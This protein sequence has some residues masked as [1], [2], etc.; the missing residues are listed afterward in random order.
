[1]PRANFT[2]FFSYFLTKIGKIANIINICYLDLFN[3]EIEKDFIKT[4]GFLLVVFL[5]S[6]SKSEKIMV[7]ANNNL[8]IFSTIAVIYY[9]IIIYY[10]FTKLSFYKIDSQNKSFC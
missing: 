8:V 4:I 6:K 10:P 9:Y 7:I 3:S 2:R 5:L 1:M